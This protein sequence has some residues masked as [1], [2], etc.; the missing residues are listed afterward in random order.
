MIPVRL[1]LA[2]SLAYT[3]SLLEVQKSLAERHVNAF[4]KL[5]GEYSMNIV[6]ACLACLIISVC[7]GIAAAL[8]CRFVDE[9]SKA[10]SSERA[11][12]AT[13]ETRFAA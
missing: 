2:T 11:E 10:V 12:A 7:G 1:R 8:F 13:G 6:V 9:P 3:T 4:E 5:F